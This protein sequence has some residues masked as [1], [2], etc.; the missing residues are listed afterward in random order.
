LNSLSSLLN[1]QKKSVAVQKEE[2]ESEAI[3]DL[4]SSISNAR[5]VGDSPDL[6]RVLSL[7]RRVLT[8]PQGEACEAFTAPLRRPG[9]TRS[10]RPLQV[11][12]LADA[13]Q[14]G[15]LLAPLGVGEGKTDIAA[16]APV[17]LDAK[18]TVM[19]LP[20]PLVSKYLH[21]EYPVL[22]KEYKLP[23]VVGHKIQYTDTDR[24]VY[25]MSYDKLSRPESTGLLNSIK[26][27]LFVLDEAH[28]L[29]NPSSVRTRR[30]KRYLKEHPETKVVALS[31]S[32]TKKSVGDYAHIAQYALKEGSP[33]PLDWKV[34]QDWKGALDS[35]DLPAPPGKL[36]ELC[37]PGDSDVRAGFRRRLLETPGV[38]ASSAESKVRLPTSLILSERPLP[39]TENIKRELSRL[40]DTW[41]TPG[42]EEL[43]SALDFNRAARQLAGGLYLKWTWPKREPLDIRKEWLEARKEWHKEVR[44]FLKTSSKEGLDSPMLVARAASRGDIET[45]GWHRWAAIKDKAEPAT[46]PVWVDE[47]MVED[48][49]KWGL[50]NVGIIWYE[51]E[52]LGHK[53]SE[54]GGFPLFGGGPRASL[55]I[56]R[57]SGKRTIVASVKAH[58]EGKNLQV[59]N[60]GLVTTTSSSGK[61][62][63][64][65]LGRKHRPGQLADEVTFDIYLHTPEMRQAF[66]NALNDAEYFAQTIG[67]E[68]RLQVATYTFEKPAANKIKD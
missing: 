9:G 16:L 68:Q 54:K 45:N 67:D 46:L 3:N 41:C 61:T 49:V 28:R 51:H 64:Q 33:L 30:W 4:F 48:A 66:S 1:K 7:P 18:V 21:I 56:Q 19:F 58:G 42:G 10:L 36:L 57:E 44:Q 12:A 55:E 27:D 22:S 62:W 65:L 26:P 6:Y 24:L 60:R 2:V 34:L 37:E 15:G 8:P 50:D 63:E 20:A 5:P 31:G 14:V 40:R 11:L 29:A 35:N 17:M 23:N 25:V 53:I 59:F 32:I 39:L 13:A 43:Q 47:Y 52:A 38:V